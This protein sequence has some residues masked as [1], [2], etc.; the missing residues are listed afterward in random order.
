MPIDVVDI[1][2]AKQQA[3][4]QAA[5]LIN[6]AQKAVTE[7][8]KATKQVSSILQDAE[9]ANAAATAANTRMQ[10]IAAEYDE[11]KADIDTTM[12]AAAGRIVDNK[13]AEATEGLNTDAYTEVGV[14]IA[15]TLLAK[16]KKLR[17]KKK[18]ANAV[19]TEVVKNYT[20]TGQNED[21]AMTQKAIT[22]ALK[23]VEDKISAVPSGGNGAN[24]DLGNA[25]PGTLVV[26]G[27]NGGIAAG[28]TTEDDILQM[29]MALGTYDTSNAIGITVDYVNRS[30]SRLSNGIV[31][32]D[33]SPFGGRKRCTVADDGSIIAFE[34][35]IGYVE[36]GSNGQV[37]VYQPKFYYRRIPTKT[38]IINTGTRID[39][40]TIIISSTPQSN[41][42]IHPLFLDTNGNIVDY[43]LLSAYEGC[44]YDTSTNTYNLTD[45]QDV[46]FS[47]DLLCSIIGA[48]PISGTTQLFDLAAAT[49]MAS[50][51]GAG[52]QITDLAFESMN[53]MLM[54]VEFGALNIQNAFFKGCTELDTYGAT[55]ASCITG[56]TSSLGSTSGR[57]PMTTRTKNGSTYTY[58]EDGKCSISY[59]GFENPYG[60]MW[61]FI[62]GLQVVNGHASYTSNRAAQTTV[63]YSLPSSSNWISG[64]GYDAALPWAYI[65]VEAD[66]TATSA[67]P[68]GDFV[69]VPTSTDTTVCVIGGS[70]VAAS[71]AGPFYYDCTSAP[72]KHSYIYSARLMHVPTANST[73]HNNNV[74]L[75]QI[76]VGSDLDD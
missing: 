24:I 5:T 47:T 45:T 38:S 15:D 14:T 44:A 70:G 1:M 49:Q 23:A 76:K 62:G 3:Q 31:F 10:E 55:N 74:A 6:K 9:D 51:R 63:T 75:W 69:Y 56:S 29:Q 53:Q 73:I 60:N 36:D 37:M 13:I 71:N 48:K 20:A 32:N 30:V 34:G 4:G 2:L 57:A 8:N 19:E 16:I 17:T 64:F 72:T 39:A 42:S 18:N 7:A 50:N 28:S 25:T 59:R 67:V 12:E 33:H 65:P 22:D 11:I 40:E 66:A 41:L 54:A 21:G 46:D 58:S 26:V 35:D 27:E 52:W 43:V 61:R 68:V